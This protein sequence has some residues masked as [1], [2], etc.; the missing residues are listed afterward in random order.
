MEQQKQD[1]LSHLHRILCVLNSR[2]QEADS[3]S[4]CE[5]VHLFPFMVRVLF[6]A[7]LQARCKSD[8]MI[9]E[10]VFMEMH[11]TKLVYPSVE[12]F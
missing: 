11:G 12:T 10:N 2:S 4:D 9:S 1:S 8:N 5:D 6:G 3:A 7:A